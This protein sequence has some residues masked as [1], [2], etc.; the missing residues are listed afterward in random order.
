MD[1]CE[2]LVLLFILGNVCFFGTFLVNHVAG[3]RPRIDGGT[4]LS[5][6]RHVNDQSEDKR[7]WFPDS[8][9]RNQVQQH[10]DPKKNEEGPVL[11]G[12]VS[13]R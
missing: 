1:V 11:N 13:M 4:V 10:M 7:R 2:G 12:V 9:R 3:L 6:F 8:N 5:G